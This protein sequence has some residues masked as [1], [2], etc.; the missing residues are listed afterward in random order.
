MNI[1]SKMVGTGYGA[2]KGMFMGPIWATHYAYK[3]L[4]DPSNLQIRSNYYNN[5][6]REPNALVKFLCF[7]ISL[8]AIPYG[9]D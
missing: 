9:C 2:I 3:Y 6:Y 8:F 5:E 7:S 4:A 1:I